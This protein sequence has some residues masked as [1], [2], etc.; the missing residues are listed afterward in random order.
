MGARGCKVD[1]MG[2]CR[3]SCMFEALA[4]PSCQVVKS[5]RCVR[6]A[7]R[8]SAAPT[9]VPR[10]VATEI[11]GAIAA[12]EHSDLN[13]H[14]LHLVARAAAGGQERRGGGE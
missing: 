11:A 14:F 7:S 5:A 2:C 10:P 8:H 9:F 4:L 6:L 1:P 3:G 12:A 13:S